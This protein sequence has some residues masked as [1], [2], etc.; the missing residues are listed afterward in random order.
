MVIVTVSDSKLYLLG[1]LG[2]IPIGIICKIDNIIVSI[3][4]IYKKTKL[5][6]K[7]IRHHSAAINRYVMNIY[8]FNYFLL[9][10]YWKIYFIGFINKFYVQWLINCML[11]IK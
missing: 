9:L 4:L 8:K 10:K 3:I 6:D 2:L 11:D 1:L 7:L 5:S